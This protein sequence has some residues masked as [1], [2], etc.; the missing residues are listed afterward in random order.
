[1]LDGV[2]LDKYGTGRLITL[3][4]YMSATA[5]NGTKNT[6]NLQAD[7]FGDWREEVI[8]HSSDNSKL[9]IFTTTTPTSRRLFTLMHDPMYRLGIAWQNVGYNQ[10][11]DVSF[12]LGTGMGTPP[13]PNINLK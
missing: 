10:P 2:N 12:Y 9:I 1:L 3:S 5:N 4:G 11:P 8:L 7:I 6:P 13:M